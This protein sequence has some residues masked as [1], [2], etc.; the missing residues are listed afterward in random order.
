MDIIGICSENQAYFIVI[1]MM[2]WGVLG[3]GVTDLVMDMREGVDHKNTYLV[4]EG[5]F[6]GLGRG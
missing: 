2:N 4:E 1:I 6:Q 3:D 5:S